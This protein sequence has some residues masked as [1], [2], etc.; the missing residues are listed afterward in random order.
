LQAPPPVLEEA[1][2]DVAVMT[3]HVAQFLVEDGDWRGTL[4]D[5]HRALVQSGRLAFDTRDPRAQAWQHWNARETRRGVPINDGTA[6][7][8][9]NEVTAVTGDLV[10]FTLHYLFDDGEELTSSASTRFRSEESVSDAVRAAGYQIRSIFG[11]SG[12]E[13]VGSSDGEL[14]VL[15]DRPH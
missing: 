1:A 13:P 15:A 14:L 10:T 7:E 8:V 6:V 12:G 9:W 2:F 5:L 4:R 11:G 3:A